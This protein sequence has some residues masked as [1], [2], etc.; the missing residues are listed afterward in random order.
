[1]STPNTNHGAEAVLRYV[2]QARRVFFLGIGGVSMCSLAELTKKIGKETAGYDRTLTP[3][4]RRLADMGIS[5]VSDEGVHVRAG[6]AVVYTVAISPEHPDYVAA[7]E[8][9]LPLISR[10]DYLGAVMCRYGCRMGVSGMHGK[11]TT[12]AML[13]AI[14]EAAGVNPTV[15]AGAAI[16]A[17]GSTCKLGGEDYFVFE[18]CEYMDSFLSFNPTC[19][20]VLN[21]EADHLDYFTSMEHIRTSF[22]RFLGRTGAAENAMAIVNGDDKET[23]TAAQAYGGKKITFGL[24][25]GVD[26]RA[27]NVSASATGTSFDVRRH[28]ELLAHVTLRSVGVH[29]VSDALAAFAAACENGISPTAAAEGLAAYEGAQRR[30]EK[31][32]TLSCGADVYEDYAHHPTEI[33]ASLAAARLMGYGRILCAFQS[34]TYSRTA[35]LYDDFITAFGETDVLW[36]APIYA[37]REENVYGLDEAK[38]ARDAGAVALPSFDAVAECIRAE[39]KAGDMVILMGAGDI[40]QVT[41]LLNCYFTL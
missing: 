28:G 37:A 24:S 19:A 33:R 41:K 39:A 14:C 36:F 2:D 8:M 17:Y 5:I 3:V 11:S 38:F 6:D 32:G 31:K 13:A 35:L 4:T 27:E 16:P 23:M 30:M 10:A 22:G 34:H 25:A 15:F 40:N 1:M 26:Y 7:Q 20:I 29:F 12:T 18:A 9:N 21:V